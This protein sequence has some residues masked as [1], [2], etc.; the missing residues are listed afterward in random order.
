MRSLSG[1]NQ[2][3]RV[4]GRELARRPKLLIAVQPTRGLDVG[5]IDY[6]H[7]QLIEQRSTGVAILL[8]STELEEVIAL[9][10]R[11][12]VMREGRVMALP[13]KPSIETIGAAM[14]G[15]VGTVMGA[16]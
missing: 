15:S 11:I 13:D 14:L 7:R 6:V 3:K 9:S 2:Q 1:G 12:V 10:D 5:A 16:P 4:L 8:I